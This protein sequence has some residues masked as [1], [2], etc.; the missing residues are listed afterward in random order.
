MIEFKGVSKV[1]PGGKIALHN[2]NFK[3][4]DGQFIAFIGT[5]GSGKTTC[6]RM[7]NKMIEPSSGEVLINGQNIKNLNDVELR[8]SIGYVIQ[9][10]GLMPHMTIFENI[11]MVPRLLKTPEE[12]IKKIAETM[13]KKV[14]L[15]VEYLSRYPKELSGGQQQ[16][17]GVI[18]ALS[19]NQDIILMDEPFGALD[20]ITREN[21]Q[22]L[23]KNLQ[24]ELGK[25]F[26]FVTHDIDEAFTLADKIA[27]MDG[28][29]LIQYDTPDNILKAP[30]NDF[31]KN[32]LGEKRFDS[33]KFDYLPVE[34]VMIRN[35]KFI[36]QD[37]T[38]R[39]AME[40]MHKSRVDTLFLVDDDSVLTG[41]VD[42]FDIRSSRDKDAQISSYMMPV[43]SL[44]RK[45]PLKDAIFY[46]NNLGY[47]NM[48]IVD[49]DLHLIGVVTRASV[50]DII[51]SGFLGDYKPTS[52]TV[53]V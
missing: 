45:T 48:P 43:Q 38:V 16:R 17:I 19:A 40:M 8:R 13:I 34:E 9:Q 37:K 14:D 46:I 24:M 4:D 15:P 36:H 35:P 29:Q 41:L 2:I 23:V 31:V 6:M 25:T 21:L 39:E 49:E 12:E 32:L 3:I 50:M 28:G 11:V 20:P 53:E 1:Y 47:R 22:I 10:I 5:S 52:N 27:I 30:A 51:Y 44:N 26:I 18:R 33:A 42:V 7:I